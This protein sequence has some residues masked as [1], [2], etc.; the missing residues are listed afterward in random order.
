MLDY[1]V[2]GW[3][4]SL[5]WVAQTG[6]PITITAGPG[7]NY[8]NGA[9]N[10][11]QAANAIRIGNPFAGG[12]TPPAGNV[13][14]DAAATCPTQVKPSQN[15]YNPC[16]FTDPLSGDSQA[17][18]GYCWIFSGLPAKR[19]RNSICLGFPKSSGNRRPNGDFISGGKQNQIY[20]PGYERV[21]MSLFKNFHTW[22]AQNS[23]PRG[24]LQPA[25]SSD[26]F[27]R[28]RQPE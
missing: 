17:Q 12:G 27:R 25:Q 15:W 4:T 5:T 9:G 22:R 7:N 19:P 1:I 23:V 11:L 16:A 2:G 28:R 14:T 3:Q 21:N 18:E 6:N 20:G 24:R 26:F 8:G 10:G 13:D